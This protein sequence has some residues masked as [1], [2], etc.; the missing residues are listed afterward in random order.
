M[1]SS[2]RLLM[3]PIRATSLPLL[4]SFLLLCQ[5]QVKDQKQKIRDMLEAEGLRGPATL[6]KCKA[7]RVKR[8]TKAEV[9]S[10]DLSNIIDENVKRSK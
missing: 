10:L 8:E 5:H 6:E 2:Q 4:T 3:L 1:K 7:L 9:A